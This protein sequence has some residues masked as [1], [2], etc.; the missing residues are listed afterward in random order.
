MQ[1]NYN[2]IVTRNLLD[3]SLR[4]KGV[5]YTPS[6]GGLTHLEILSSYTL[7]YFY[8]SLISIQMQPINDTHNIAC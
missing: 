7:I 5:E 8:R 2:A 4:G 3:H 1:S 6:L